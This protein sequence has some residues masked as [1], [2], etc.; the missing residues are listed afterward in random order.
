MPLTAVA[1]LTAPGSNAVRFTSYPS[2]PGVRDPVFIYCNP[3]G[4]RLGTLNA[5]SP[6][7]TAPYNFTW[8][9][10][11]DATGSFSQLIKT[12]TGVMS[13]SANNLDEGGYR[14]NIAGGGGYTAILTGWI[15]LD[16]PYALAA[17]MNRTCDYVALSG[18]VAV[19]TF[20]YRDPSGGNQVRLP[21]GVRFRWSS[22][23]PS[24]IPFPEIELNPLTF[25]PPLVDVTYK[26]QATDSLTCVSE[27]SFFYESMHVKADFSVSPERGDAPLEVT[28][29][30]KSVRAFKYRWEF[31][32][33][34]VSLLDNPGQH[35]Y[36]TPGEYTVKLTIE[37]ELHCIDSMRFSKIVVNP[38]ALQIPNVFTPDGDGLNDNFVVASQSL[39]YINVD[40]YSR[41]GLKVYSF[42]GQGDRLREWTGW[43]GNV[44]N[45]SIKAAP[46]IYFY[47]IKAKGWDDVVYDNKEYRGFV[48]LYR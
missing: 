21:N 24:S 30:D 12:E 6:G 44:N 14:V 7:G 45:S 11:S 13:S 29:T 48:Y 26:L 41:S 43:D 25:S 10:W 15:F 20:Y 36:Y 4:T 40:I 31:G 19:D 32:D 39:R 2:D 28:F 23:P 22:D 16:K 46:G 34:T 37:S 9:K 5:V 33:D 35:I 38:S 17:L 3:T 18:K 8:Y 47:I 42:D 27:S 1:Q